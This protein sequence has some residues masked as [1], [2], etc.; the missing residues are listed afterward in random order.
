M[1]AACV[2]LPES[3]FVVVEGVRYEP[4][5]SSPIPNFRFGWLPVPFEEAQAFSIRVG[6]KQY[7]SFWIRPPGELGNGFPA[8]TK[9]AEE[10]LHK[11]GLCLKGVVRMMNNFSGDQKTNHITYLV[12]CV[13][14]P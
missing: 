12:E 4:P 14:A 5:P 1:L 7:H 6:S 2:S 3:D 10:E 13:K 8:A 11:R 9:L